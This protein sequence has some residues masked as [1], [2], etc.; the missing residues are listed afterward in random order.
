MSQ[1]NVRCLLQGSRKPKRG[2]PE[3]GKEKGP[4]SRFGGRE[5]K[6]SSEEEG[7][8]HSPERCLTKRI[9]SAKKE[10]AWLSRS[11]DGQV[12][13]SAIRKARTTLYGARRG[14]GKKGG[15]LRG[16]GGGTL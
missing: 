4:H 9:S 8:S 16:G 11:P 1:G 13:A 6:G 15:V 3:E 7:F 5:I 12:V 10:E 14:T 2:S